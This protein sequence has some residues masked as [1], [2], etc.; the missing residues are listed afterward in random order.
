M[1]VTCILCKKDKTVY[2][3]KKKYYSELIHTVHNLY[4]CFDCDIMFWFP[5]ILPDFIYQNN[6]LRYYTIYHMEEITYIPSHV[7]PFFKHF[8]YLNKGRILDIGCSNG[9]FLKEC[10][11]MGLEPYG[12]DLDPI[13]I[14]IA[15]KKGLK[16]VFNLSFDEF[17]QFAVKN[18]LKF[19]IITMFEFLEHQINPTE[20]FSKVILLLNK[21][22]FVVGSVPNRESVF[23]KFFRNFSEGEFPPHHYTWWSPNAIY[24]FLSRY[25]LIDINLELCGDLMTLTPPVPQKLRRK[26]KEFFIK[27]THYTN[28]PISIYQK[29]EMNNTKKII[30]NIFQITK[31]MLLSILSVITAEKDNINIYFQAKKS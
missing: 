25:G 7:K 31:K 18:N 22:G 15:K 11:K 24:K 2:K 17:F 12:V 23:T 10:E 21:N 20:V 16:N 9:S 14:E 5:L 3:L 4:F 27:D 6:L 1:N 30:F 28:L 29:L 13:S 19:D 26:I 8:S